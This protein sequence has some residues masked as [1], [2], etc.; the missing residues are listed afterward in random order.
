MKKIFLLLSF[1]TVMS[2]DTMKNAHGSLDMGG[3][4]LVNNI[5][6]YYKD[7]RT[8]LCFATLAE[9]YIPADSRLLTQVP[10]TEK[11]LQLIK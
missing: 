10:C 6:T 1:I 5:I 11:V 7:K 8:D 2:C 4:Y 3:N 9:V